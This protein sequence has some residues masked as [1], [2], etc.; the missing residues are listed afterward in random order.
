[1]EV[2]QKQ[3]LKFLTI[4]LVTILVGPEILLG[5]ELASL[6]ELIGVV[7]FWSSI[8]IGI[9]MHFVYGVFTPVYHLLTKWDSNFFIPDRKIIR[10]YPAMLI[11]AVPS[12]LLT[13]SLVGITLMGKLGNILLHT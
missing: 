2:K 12:L 3:L 5:L 10:E 8:W 13:Y 4:L 7:A 1:M 11:H 9:K 6:I